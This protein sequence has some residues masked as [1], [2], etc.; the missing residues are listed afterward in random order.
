MG[1]DLLLLFVTEAP[2]NPLKVIALF[3]KV[4]WYFCFQERHGIFAVPT[5][6]SFAKAHYFLHL[7]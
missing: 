1:S 6:R 4:T 5:I 2:F 7:K 3:D